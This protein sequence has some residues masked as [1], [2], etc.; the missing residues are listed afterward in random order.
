MYPYSIICFE[1][2]IY[3]YVYLYNLDAYNFYNTI[4]VCG[5]DPIINKFKKNVEIKLYYNDATQ[6]NC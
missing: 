2:Y 1:I 4:S 3:T 5:F 6:N